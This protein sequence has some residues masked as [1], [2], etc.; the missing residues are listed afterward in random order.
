MLTKADMITKYFWVV[1]YKI[2]EM[3][4]YIKRYFS[5][6]AMSMKDLARKREGE[7]ERNFN[8]SF[9]GGRGGTSALFINIT[10]GFCKR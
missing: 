9:H 4:K 6:N 1:I 5:L 2:K 10:S 7:K 3:V 8:W